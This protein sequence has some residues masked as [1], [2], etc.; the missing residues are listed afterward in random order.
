[1]DASTSS[2]GAYFVAK[3]GERLISQPLTFAVQFR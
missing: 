3:K 2:G 1:M